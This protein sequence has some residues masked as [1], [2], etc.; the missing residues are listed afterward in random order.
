MSSKEEFVYPE[1]I[2]F[3]LPRFL[4]GVGLENGFHDGQTRQNSP[5]SDI[6]TVSIIKLCFFFHQVTRNLVNMYCLVPSRANSISSK[7]TRSSQCA[8]G[9]DTQISYLTCQ[10]LISSKLDHGAI[11]W[12]VDGPMWQNQEPCNY[13]RTL[14]KEKHAPPQQFSHTLNSSS[15][16]SGTFSYSNMN[17]PNVWGEMAVR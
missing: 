11:A 12:L 3:L 15:W 16:H 7:W 6:D 9:P 2:N 5:L 4:G 10:K 14:F 17:F 1:F 13:G 8:V